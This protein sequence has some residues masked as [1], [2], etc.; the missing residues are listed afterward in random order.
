M[1][2]QETSNARTANRADEESLPLHPSRTQAVQEGRAFETEYRLRRHDGGYEW[3]LAQGLPEYDGKGNIVKW[4]GS[5]TNVDAQ[6]R[7]RD[8]AR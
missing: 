7:A 5:C 6:R 1:P 4:Y 8:R 2:A 3:F